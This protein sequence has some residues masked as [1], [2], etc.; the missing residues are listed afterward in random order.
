ME[1]KTN[2][3]PIEF[4]GKGSEFFGIWIVNFFLSAIT[5]GIYSAW[6]K[7]RTKRYFYGNT[8]IAGDNFDYHAMPMQI[9]KGR[10]VAVAVLFVWVVSSSFSPVFSSLLLFVFYCALPW[11]LWSNARF[12]A[13]M[14]SYRNVRFSFNASL[15]DAYIA[16]M[17]RGLGAVILFS[18]YAFVVVSL[19]QV[20]FLAAI[21]MGVGSLFFMA[22]LHAWIMS[23]MLRYFV[24]GYKFGEWQFSAKIE[25][26]FF[27]KTYLKAMGL[28]ILVFALI[29]VTTLL[30]IFGKNDVSQMTNGNFSSLMDMTN[31]VAY[32]LAYIA[33]LVVMIVLTAYTA[34]C[35]HNYVIS[36]VQSKLNEKDLPTYTFASTLTVSGYAWLI[37]SNFLLQ[38]VTL[39]LARAWVMVRTMRYIADN[40]T[41]IGDMS[42]L[43]AIDQGSNVKSAV[44]D[45]L[46]QAFDLGIGIG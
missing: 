46:A 35:V 17:G 36:Q 1:Q 7:V 15:K 42:G 39:G 6:A 25:L 26:G 18:I 5:L 27:V 31:T 9:L 29:G 14:T 40:T 23:G 37:I 32:V 2:I 41:V 45:E 33:I 44:T 24:N 38:V 16:L 3:N 13:A 30:T 12:D 10:L 19:F 43:K 34:T 11:L 21:V 22:A 20:S 8:Y 28:G 4:K